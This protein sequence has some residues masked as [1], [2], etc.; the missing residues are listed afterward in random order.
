M[1]L[2]HDSLPLGPAEQAMSY[3]HLSPSIWNPVGNAL[4]SAADLLTGESVVDLFA[5]AGASAVPAAQEVRASG[6]VTAVDLAPEP[7]ALAAEKAATLGLH[8]LTTAVEDARTFV[9]TERPDAVLLGFGI[10]LV[11]D[12]VGL[13]SRVRG[14][15]SD[16]GRLALST[17]SSPGLAPLLEPFFEAAK[18]HNPALSSIV[19]PAA[20]DR[21]ARAS[22]P[23]QMAD[24]LRA[25]G[26]GAVESG[27]IQ[28]HVSFDELLL[29]DFV[30]G[31]GLRTLLSPTDA[32]VNGRI[33]EDYMEAVLDHEMLDFMGTVDIHV[34]RG[35]SA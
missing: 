13:L 12:P 2:P 25:A 5:G 9:P 24:D 27:Q 1:A 3:E 30:Q 31:T 16:E 21:I 15:L 34:A 7:L 22:D 20:F 10:F 6:H 8:N 33:R 32:A 35:H 29:W 26:F 11:S 18:R 4:V 19:R 17:W 28:L 23:C 14:Y